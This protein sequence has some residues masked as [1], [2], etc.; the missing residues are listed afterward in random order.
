[1]KNSRDMSYDKLART[2]SKMTSDEILY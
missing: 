1:M 2:L